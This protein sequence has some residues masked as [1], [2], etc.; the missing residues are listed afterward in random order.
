MSLL[1]WSKFSVSCPGW[2]GTR[3]VEQVSRDLTFSFL[4]SWI[5]GIKAWTARPGSMFPP[6]YFL[7]STSL[8]RTCQSSGHYRLSST[9]NQQGKSSDQQNSFQDG[10]MGSGALVVRLL[11]LSR[12]EELKKPSTKCVGLVAADTALW[13]EIGW[14]TQLYLRISTQTNQS[15]LKA[16]TTKEILWMSTW[17]P[18]ANW[19]QSSRMCWKVSCCCL[20]KLLCLFMAAPRVHPDTQS[21]GIFLVGFLASTIGNLGLIANSAAAPHPT[22]PFPPTYLFCSQ[23]LAFMDF[24][25]NSPLSP[26]MHWCISAWS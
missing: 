21:S 20:R 7:S 1:V 3:S 13:W 12:C 26:Q 22:L 15:T 24:C 23:T 5:A 4:H 19:Q 25:N 10:V 2:P 17:L 6:S 11:L 14:Q 8:K 9:C 16:D 18:L